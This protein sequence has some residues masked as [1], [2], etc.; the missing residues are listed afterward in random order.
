[1]ALR[2]LNRISPNAS[3]KKFALLSK[4]STVGLVGIVVLMVVLIG[5]VI[6]F[7]T[8]VPSPSDLQNQDVAQATRI[9]DRNGVLLYNIFQNQNRTPVKLADIPTNVKNAT[10]SIEDRNFY[11]EAGFS[12]TGILRSVFQLI[13]HR[14]IEG[15]GSTLT[16]QLV[17]NTLLTNEVSL[18]RK[19]KELIL[20]IQVERVY[21]KDQILEMYFNA[22]PYGGTAY[23]IESAA[24][25][26]FGKH[27]RQLDLAEASLLAGLPQ[28]PSVYSP[29]GTHPELAKVRQKEVLDSMVSNRYITRSQADAAY[30]EALTYRTAKKQL[31]FKAPHFVLYVKEKLIE[32]FGEKMVE[33]GGLRVTTTLDENLQEDAQKIV[34]DE[35]AGL[36]NYDV[37]NGAALIEDPNN[38]QILAMIGSKDY[39]GKSEPSGCTSGVDCVFDPN[40]NAALSE[41]QPGSAT[42]PITYS[43]A[44]QKHYTAAT[45]LEDVQTNFSGGVGQPVYA[46]VNYD[47]K[48]RG[49]IQVR[50]ALGNSIN[51]PAVKMLAMV[52]IKNDMDLAYRMGLSNW[53]PTDENVNNVG[54]SLTLGGRETS[55]IDLTT[56]YD[57]LADKGYRH[58]PVSILKVTDSNGKILYEYHDTPGVKILD[59]GITYIISNILADNGARSAEFG[60]NSVLVVPGHTVSV[61]TGTTDEKRDNWTIGYT[62]SFVVGVWVGNS[63]NKPMN[64]VISSGIT[65][66][67]PIWQKLMERAL[68]GKGDET[69]TQPDDVSYTDVDG[70]MGGKPHNGQPTRKEYFI[71]GTEPSAESSAY[72]NLKVCKNNPHQLSGPGDDGDQKDMIQLKEDDPTGANTW[73]DGINKWV[74]TASNPQFVGTAQGCNGIPGF[75]GGGTGGVISIVN[76]SNGANVPSVFD[77]LAN[78]NSPN[79]VKSVTWSVDGAQK[80]VESGAPFAQHIEFPKGDHGSHT[81]TV[82]LV[83]NNGQSYSTSIGVTVAL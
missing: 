78:V 62:P 6:Y 38:G 76:I 13:I 72:Q 61:K 71:K 42:K 77:V 8:Q 7:A 65:G 24:N 59:E 51:I 41:R 16:Q 23:G 2:R 37:G 39:F 15:G 47:G 48:F 56:A 34:T 53:V 26:Y 12:I 11:N 54:L 57:V 10:I 36:T 79:G 73:Q 22:I 66:A 20:A 55:L 3:Y 44:L 33:Q 63:N 17:K 21:S 14:Q 49:P 40:V 5:S 82:T 60:S 70:L 19:I 35:I 67:S 45:V 4:L 52:G 50:Y 75:A 69:Y 68:K 64:P 27:A 30:R 9:Y 18:V 80:N 28:E 83:D 58:D 81:I 32:Q 43:L 74:L 25:L 46:P 1:M 31:G 29:Y